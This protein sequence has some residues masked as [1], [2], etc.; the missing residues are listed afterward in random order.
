MV[1][2]RH[3]SH[4]GPNSDYLFFSEDGPVTFSHSPLPL[5]LIFYFCLHFAMGIY[6]HFLGLL[7]EMDLGI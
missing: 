7:I 3:V 5:V 6:V 2:N 1:T 4:V